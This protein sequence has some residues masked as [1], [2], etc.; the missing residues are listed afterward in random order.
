[1][2]IQIKKVVKYSFRMI[3]GIVIRQMWSE[4]RILMRQMRRRKRYY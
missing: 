4:K 2:K 1:M 3:R